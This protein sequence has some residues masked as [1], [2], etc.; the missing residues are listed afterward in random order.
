MRVYSQECPEVGQCRCVAKLW[1]MWVET[2]GVEYPRGVEGT[3]LRIWELVTV[4][5]RIEEANTNYIVQLLVPPPPPPPGVILSPRPLAVATY[6]SEGS[7]SVTGPLGNEN[8][9]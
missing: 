7:N 9:E 3:W 5:P 1:F 8:Q 4:M 6:S 2:Q